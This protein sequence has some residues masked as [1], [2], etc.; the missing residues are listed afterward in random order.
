MNVE[1]IGKTRK[2]MPQET[3][4]LIDVKNRLLTDVI[5]GAYVQG[6]KRELKEEGRE[7][8]ESLRGIKVGRFLNRLFLILAMKT[9]LFYI[10]RSLEHST[11]RRYETESFS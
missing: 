11:T 1:I 7:I 10:I 9:F 3:V 4:R 6:V 8:N 2:V 5:G